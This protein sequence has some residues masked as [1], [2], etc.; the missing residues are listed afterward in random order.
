MRR[1]TF[2]LLLLLAG[3]A[4]PAEGQDTKQIRRS[5][6]FR[7]DPGGAELGMLEPGA[8]VATGRTQGNWIAVT[9]DGWVYSPSV[10]RTNRGGFD[11]VVSADGGE[12]LRAAPN[13]AKVARLS[14]GALLDRRTTQ[15]RWIRVRREGWALRS[16]FAAPAAQPTPRPPA[17]AA[18]PMAGRQ[19][20]RM[21]GDGQNGQGRNG[22]GERVVTGTNALLSGEPGGTAVATLADGAEGE[23][24]ARS[25]EWVKLR[26][27]GWVSASDVRS[28]EGGPRRG[29][30]AAEV[31]A[32]PER[33]LGQMLEWRLQLVAVRK[34]DA[35]RPE[36]P[37]GREYLL[38]RG[39][40]PE[41]GFVYVVISPA[42]AERFK[43]MPPLSELTVRGVL[44]AASTRW[45]P[46]PVIDLVEVVG[47]P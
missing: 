39:P 31:R 29:V 37:E 24:V 18:T 13:G 25:G 9:L 34:A 4:A 47:E 32:Q 44:R 42:Q 11:L 38:A 15:G 43:A 45:L 22:D 12:N 26:I 40:L 2:L 1:K 20:G 21:A 19:D 27:E 6:A 7:K 30:S 33:W 46:N 3:M 35:L 8:R 5:S 17:A 41:S 28:A 16:A 36:L 23:V 10:A 14:R